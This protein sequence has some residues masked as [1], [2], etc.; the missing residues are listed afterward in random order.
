MCLQGRQVRSRGRKG[1]CDAWHSSMQLLTA[2]AVAC[3]AD[4]V[5]INSQQTAPAGTQRRGRLALRGAPLLLPHPNP[6]VHL[7]ARPRSWR[8]STR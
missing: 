3:I 8:A 6:S 5:L 2:P 7:L 4:A 1:V